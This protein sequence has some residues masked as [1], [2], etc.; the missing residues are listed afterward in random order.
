MSQLQEKNVLINTQYT[1]AFFK[2]L[3]TLNAMSHTPGKFNHFSAHGKKDNWKQN[4]YSTNPSDFYRHLNLNNHNW[5]TLNTVKMDAQ[6]R[7]DADIANLNGHML[8]IDCLQNGIQPKAFISKMQQYRQQHPKSPLTIL[9]PTAMFSSGHGVYLTYLYNRPKELTQ[10]KPKQA[11]KVLDHYRNNQRAIVRQINVLTQR[12]FGCDLADRMAVNPARLYRMPNTYNVKY[13]DPKQK[14]TKPAKA[15]IASWSGATYD[16]DKFN[17][18]LNQH[19]APLFNEEAREKST[20]EPLHASRN[21]YGRTW[22]QIRT[23]LSILRDKQHG[24][25]AAGKTLQNRKPSRYTYSDYH[26]HRYHG[27][28]KHYG[29]TLLDYLHDHNIKFVWDN[30]GKNI[31]IP[32]S[33][34]RIKTNGGDLSSL[35]LTQVKNHYGPGSYTLMTRPSG[36]W[37]GVLDQV[38]SNGR[39]LDSITA[40]IMTQRGI[41]D[42]KLAHKMRDK[43]VQHYAKEGHT[44]TMYPWQKYGVAG[45][46]KVSADNHP[47]QHTQLQGNIM[48]K[49][50]KETRQDRYDK[51][52]KDLPMKAFTGL[53]KYHLNR[54]NKTNFN[55]M[56]RTASKPLNFQQ[57]QKKQVAHAKKDMLDNLQQIKDRKKYLSFGQGNKS[58][59][60]EQKRYIQE[61]QQEIKH[62]H[63]VTKGV[64]AKENY[65]DYLK[66]NIKDTGMPIPNLWYKKKHILNHD[67]HQTQKSQYDNSIAENYL[68]HRRGFDKSFVDFFI[69]RGLIRGIKGYSYHPYKY[70]KDGQIVKD[71]NGRKVQDM[72]KTAHMAPKVEF[73]Q[74]APRNAVEAHLHYKN[75]PKANNDMIHDLKQT[76]AEPYQVTPGAQNN[77]PVGADYIGL[78]PTKD[79]YTDKNGQKHQIYNT[80]WLKK[81]NGNLEKNKLIDRRGDGHYGFNFKTGNGTGKLYVSEAPIDAMSKLALQVKHYRHLKKTQP[82]NIKAIKAAREKFHNATY[83]SLG[84]SGDKVPNIQHFINRQFPMGHEY[85]HIIMAPD[86]DYAG[87][88]ATQQVTSEF[89][90]RDKYVKNHNHKQKTVTA[91]LPSSVNRKPGQEALRYGALEKSTGKTSNFNKDWNDELQSVTFGH[92]HL[93]HDSVDLNASQ[94]AKMTVRQMQIDIRDKDHFFKKP[95]T[96]IRKDAELADTTLQ[97]LAKTAKGYQK[98]TEKIDPYNPR[99]QMA[100]LAMKAMSNPSKDAFQEFFD[101]SGMYMSGH[102]VAN[103]SKQ[104]Y[105]AE[106]GTKNPLLKNPTVNKYLNAHYHVPQTDQDIHHIM[107]QLNSND[108][109]KLYATTLV[110]QSNI[111]HRKFFESTHYGQQGQENY[112]KL[113]HHQSKVKEYDTDHQIYAL[114]NNIDESAA[115]QAK[116]KLYKKHF[117]DYGKIVQNQKELKELSKTPDGNLDLIHSGETAKNVLDQKY[118]IKPYSVPQ[119]LDSATF[120]MDSHGIGNI[121][122]SINRQLVASHQP[123]YLKQVPSRFQGDYAQSV[124]AEQRF[125]YFH[126]KHN[127]SKQAYYRKQMQK[128]LKWIPNQYQGTVKSTMRKLYSQPNKLKTIGFQTSN[129]EEYQYKQHMNHYQKQSHI[130]K[131]NHNFKPQN[132]FQ[133]YSS[134]ISKPKPKPKKH[135]QQ[136]KA[137]IQAMFKT[138]GG[139]DL[140]G[141]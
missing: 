24:R 74:R 133:K 95:Q 43:W 67:L 109:R 139:K 107:N 2:Q 28:H 9:K 53:L 104:A 44:T 41:Y 36:K 19:V 58:D 11:K 62:D 68:I 23:S 40:F 75:N 77:V 100:H 8:D 94:Y 55:H 37:K 31:H 45:D 47:G 141:Q 99:I 7:G 117:G 48:G 46:G 38:Q 86:D 82:Q 128:H 120:N 127:L 112:K 33:E 61:S 138:Y 98:G 12:W 125:H 32:L 52:F 106:Q 15:Y 123:K 73:I 134:D 114:Q 101:Q 91:S 76:I 129:Y 135:K 70:T 5:M 17:H 113:Y 111:R 93:V 21:P 87:Y 96:Q 137:S 118:H 97:C 49:P 27:K 16:P 25:D 26:P 56:K 22:N 29:F 50:P 71:K 35:A 10:M 57:W 69:Q 121:N 124:V 14:F 80:Q 126:G 90:N 1:N 4:D 64:A 42:P 119:V 39:K 34:S 103:Y 72:S 63:N 92:H 116:T 115:W 110:A 102:E 54:I 88:S 132:M 59:T 30:S 6:H 60:R 83:L 79:T 13:Q 122:R 89:G 85:S 81:K 78:S 140:N 105:Q 108:A 3:L 18:Y 66:Q 136:S 130:L 20:T 131:P 65:Q 51:M 84:G